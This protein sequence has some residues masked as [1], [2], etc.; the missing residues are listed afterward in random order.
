MKLIFDYN[1]ANT[2]HTPE[3][4]DVDVPK[5][6]KRENLLLPDVNE[7]QII[8]HYTELSK[9][10]YGIDTNF[11]PLGSCTMK[12]NPRVNEDIAKLAGFSNIHPLTPVNRHKVH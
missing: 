1:Q 10:N 5:E 4:K 2:K 7:V 3:E 6:L 9:K 8:R 11:Y 12:Y